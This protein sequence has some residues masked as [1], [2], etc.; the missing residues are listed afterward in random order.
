MREVEGPADQACLRAASTLCDTRGAPLALQEQVLQQHRGRLRAVGQH[1][2]TAMREHNEVT[3]RQRDRR[4]LPVELE[5]GA[6]LLQDVEVCQAAGWQ[7][8][9]PGCRQLGAAED[10]A[11]DAQRT[12][13]LGQDIGTFHFED[14]RH[15]RSPPGQDDRTYS[16]EDWR[17]RILTCSATILARK[18][19]W[20]GLWPR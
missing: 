12:Q 4:T 17:F 3:A 20:N 16:Q 7:R 13:D 10:S 8:H 5:P 6:P 18:Q 19:A 15:T 11:L 2:S 1:V 9:G 14:E